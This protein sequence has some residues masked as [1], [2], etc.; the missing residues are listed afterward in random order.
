[1]KGTG[2]ALLLS[3]LLTGMGLG[4]GSVSPAHGD[5][6]IVNVF[7]EVDADEIGLLD[8]LTLTVTVEAENIKRMPKPEVPAFRDFDVVAENTS[9]QTSLSIVNGKAFRRKIISFIYTLKPKSKGTFTLEPVRIRYGGDLY[10]TEPL[11]VKVV[12]GRTRGEQ[13]RFTF[14]DGTAIDVEKLKDDIYVQIRP[15]KS[16]VVEG[17]QLFLS[18][19]L[20]SRLDIDSISLKQNPNFPGFYIEDIF[21]ATRLEYR[22]EEV[23]GR[24]YTTSLIKKVALFP[25]KAGGFAPEPLVLEATVIV[26]SDDLFDVFGRPFTFDIE[27]NP[28]EIRV[29]TL[30]PP[31]A[32]IEF[33]GIVGNLEASLSTPVYTARTGESMTCYLTLKSTGN[34]NAINDPGLELSSRGRVYLSETIRDQLEEKEKVHF[35]KKFEYTV[36]PEESGTLVVGAGEL[37]YF[38]TAEREYLTLAAEPIQ[39]TVTGENIVRERPIRDERKV[40][41]TGTLQFIKDDVKSLKSVRVSPLQS[42][43]YFMYHLGLVA[44]VV[45][46]IMIVLK[47]EKMAKNVGLLKMRRAKASALRLL[48]EAS[49]Q[50]G[51]NDL[52]AAVSTI[53]RALSSYAADKA[54]LSPQD[55]TGKTAASV[56]DRIPGIDGSTKTEYLNLF[57]TC[58]IIKFSTGLIEDRERLHD[59][60][61]QSV[62][63]INRMEI[64]WTKN[65]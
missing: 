64:E 60:R 39:L 43:P 42:F 3:I 28:V 30:P 22:K 46:L 1:M 49:S 38:D 15:E 19:T 20:Y 61:E 21:N 48:E 57:N 29:K 31:G 7:S 26:K 44:A 36:I 56:L 34:L 65:L 45:A 14:R 32:G 2:R 54:R 52:P 41:G 55:I 62:S 27:S 25:L 12:E 50:I 5:E 33:S 51:H 47:K 58:T 35:V 11:L 16:E 9:T 6:R 10:K 63:L 8:T 4:I 24:L 59:L 13:S 18:Y 37:T 17:E 53:Y 40:F 23:E